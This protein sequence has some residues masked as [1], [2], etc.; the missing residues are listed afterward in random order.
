MLKLLFPIF[1]VFLLM[2][3]S[4]L[5]QPIKGKQADSIKSKNDSLVFV[6]KV[7]DSIIYDLYTENLIIKNQNLELK[8]N[9]SLSN[10]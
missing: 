9:A 5:F 3:G 10:K 6:C 4:F 2:F 8:I 7:K 1:I